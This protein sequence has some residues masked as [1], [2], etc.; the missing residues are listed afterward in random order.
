MARG[1]YSVL[2][3]ELSGKAGSVVFVNGRNGLVIKSRGKPANPQSAA[4]LQV[5]KNLQVAAGMYKNLSAA[6]VALW[7]AYAQTQATVEP[8]SGKTYIPTAINLYVGRL[9]KL[10]QMGAVIPNPFNP[11]TSA[12]TGDNLTVSVTASTGKLTFTSTAANTTDVRTEI[13][14]AR[15]ASANRTPHLK[16]LRNAAFVRYT[17]GVLTADVNLPAGYYAAGYRFVNIT[18]GQ[19]TPIQLLPVKTV[20]LAVEK[21]GENKKAA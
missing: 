11:P 3:D 18:T 17:I 1:R 13:L 6:T 9:T 2:L 15:L 19:E 10:L 4:Q 20:T 12:F 7:K 5:R 21:G 8:V 16:D 14:V